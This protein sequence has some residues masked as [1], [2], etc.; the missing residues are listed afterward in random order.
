MTGI[1]D[2]TPT[3]HLNIQDA[4]PSSFISNTPLQSNL[5]FHDH[6][7]QILLTITKDGRLEIGPGLSKEKA[8]QEVARLLMKHFETIMKH[9]GRNDN[10]T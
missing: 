7:A 3:K 4:D 8:T 9:K 5:Y 6:K 10:E 2:D 1:D